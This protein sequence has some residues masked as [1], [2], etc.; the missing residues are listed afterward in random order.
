MRFYLD[1][2]LPTGIITAAEGLELDI[3][4]AHTVGLTG[5]G[6]AAQLL[7]AAQQGWCLVTRD[8]DD[9][10][11]LTEEFMARRLPH[12]GVLLVSRPLA[13][14]SFGTLARALAHYAGAHPEGVP[15]Y[16]IDWLWAAAED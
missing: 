15:P 1:E 4:S 13:R 9:F 16:M 14:A 6:D 5:V 11:G 7:W 3:V 8:Y 12:A 2:N 10:G